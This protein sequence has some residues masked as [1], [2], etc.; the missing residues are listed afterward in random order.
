MAKRIP[1]GDDPY[2]SKTQETRPM[3]TMPRA[4]PTPLQHAY[5]LLISDQCI[6]CEQAPKAAT[7]HLCES[8]RAEDP[9]G[10]LGRPA[11]LELTARPGTRA[12]R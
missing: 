6:W 1:G 11:Q 10:L 8:C 7:S 3:R 12:A 2:A 4:T 5:E 9:D